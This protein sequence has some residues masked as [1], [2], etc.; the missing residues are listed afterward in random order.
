MH[1]VPDGANHLL[2]EEH[3]DGRF[4][5]YGRSE[6]NIAH[7]VIGAPFGALHS[8]QRGT[9]VELSMH[10]VPDGANHLLGEAHPD[11]RFGGFTPRPMG[12][13]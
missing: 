2:G 8:P 7:G 1:G 12:A 6:P 9:G 11:G 10:G 4:G 3:P 13:E 5:A